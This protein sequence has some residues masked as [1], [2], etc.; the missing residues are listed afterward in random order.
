MHATDPVTPPSLPSLP[1]PDPAALAAMPGLVAFILEADG[2]KRVLRQNRPL[3]TERQEN[4]AEHSWQIALLAVALAPYAAEPVDLGAVVE[5]LLV[6]DLG[7]IDAGDVLLY[8]DTDWAAQK[9]AERAGV[10]RLCALLPPARG[11]HLLARWEAFDAGQSAEARFAHALDRAMPALLNLAGGGVSW[12]ANGVRHAQVIA[13]VGPPVAAGCPAL[14]AHLRAQLDAA[15]AAGW[16]GIE[17]AER[18]GA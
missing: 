12:R 7:E 4:S 1:A 14:W 13:R 16:F 18:P 15:Q 3:G 11:A 10:Q 17:A 6:H 5:M 8:A 2:L 9:A